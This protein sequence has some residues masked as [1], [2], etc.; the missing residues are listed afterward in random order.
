MTILIC[1]CLNGWTMGNLAAA[2]I[3]VAAFFY[4]LL[5]EKSVVSPSSLSQM[6]EFRPFSP[7]SWGAGMEYGLGLMVVLL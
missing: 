4:K 3:D 2:S 6:M 1:S 5:G 7:I